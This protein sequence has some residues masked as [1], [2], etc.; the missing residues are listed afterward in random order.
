MGDQVPTA[1]TFTTPW[2]CLKNMKF[3]FTTTLTT[4]WSIS[5]KQ[6]LIPS[7]KR[8]LYYVHYLDDHG[9][10]IYL[11]F[12]TTFT[13]PKWWI[14]NNDLMIFA[15]TF[16]TLWLWKKE[17]VFMLLLRSLCYDRAK[18]WINL[19]SNTTFTEHLSCCCCNV[20]YAMIL[21]QNKINFYSNNIFT[22]HF[23]IKKV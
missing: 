7:Y 8:F 3:Y 18:K 22:T 4:L 11:H 1:T 21:T 17:I 5:K 15:S 12:N 10:Y 14:T 13:T 9:K 20:H 2:W 23:F 16:V 6:I 19:H